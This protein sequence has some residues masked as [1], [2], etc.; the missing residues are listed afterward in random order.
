M[1]SFS[2]C[3]SLISG[4]V[5]APLVVLT[6]QCQLSRRHKRTFIPVRCTLAGWTSVGA[7]A[8]KR[9]NNLDTLSA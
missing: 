8:L 4:A 7:G 5:F 2:S 9:G 3:H 6:R 1:R